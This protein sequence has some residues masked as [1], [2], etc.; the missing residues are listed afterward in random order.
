MAHRLA[1]QAE[2]DLDNIWYYVTQ[3]S[4]SMEIA[5]QLVDSIT[6]RFFLLAT[7]PHIG[8]RRDW[9]LRVGLRS[10]PVG[11]FVII[12]RAEDGD[13]LILRVFQGNRDIEGLLQQ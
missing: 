10:F 2:A 9:D 1:P 6:Q 8:R 7:Y 5:D 3:Q 13:G 11:R 4:G 12:Y